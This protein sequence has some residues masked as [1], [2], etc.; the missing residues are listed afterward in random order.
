L[1]LDREKKTIEVRSLISRKKKK[2]RDD[3]SMN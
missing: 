1:L 3:D 2:E